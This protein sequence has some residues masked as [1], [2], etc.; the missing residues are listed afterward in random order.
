MQ[1][2]LIQNINPNISGMS[3]D[4]QD[5]NAF[6]NKTRDNASLGEMFLM[7]LWFENYGWTVT[8]FGFVVAFGRLVNFE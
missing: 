7:C 5:P 3:R 1:S 8:A 6:H 4:T 2:Y